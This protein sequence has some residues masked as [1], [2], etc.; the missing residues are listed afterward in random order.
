MDRQ[1]SATQ[2]LI[3]IADCNPF[4]RDK[5]G[6]GSLITGA[7]MHARIEQD[8]LMSEIIGEALHKRVVEEHI[9]GA[10]GVQ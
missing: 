5:T 1:E 4:N 9:V 2:T 8:I 6:L 7:I 3:V 10:A